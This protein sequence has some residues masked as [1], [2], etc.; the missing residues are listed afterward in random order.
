MSSVIPLHLK[1]GLSLRIK[2]FVLLLYD[3]D[4]ESYKKQTEL[5]EWM[6]NQKM[7]T[8]IIS[9]FQFQPDAGLFAS[10]RNA[11]LPVFLSRCYAY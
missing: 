11:Q 6:L 2:T 10:R 1:F 9:N 7:F 3:A 8:K 5:L 4:A